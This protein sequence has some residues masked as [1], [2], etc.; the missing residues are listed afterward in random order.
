MR[1]LAA[2]AVVALALAAQAGAA[3]PPPAV[4]AQAQLLPAI[5]LF[6]DT[7]TAQVD[8]TLDRSRVDPDT[9][10]VEADFAPWEPVSEPERIRRDGAAT[11]HIRTRFVLRCLTGPCLPAQ[12][13]A[14]LEFG[15]AVVTYPGGE[16]V[17]AR[18][19]VLAVHSRIVSAEAPP[20]VGP[21]GGGRRRG[22]PEIPWRADV[23]A[24]PAPTYRVAPGIA[25]P[26]LLAGGSLLAACGLALGL[27]ALPRR[28]PA[29]APAPEPPPPPLPPLE[30]ALALLEDP[31]PADGAADRRRALELVADHVAARD[32]RLART[33]R[34]LAWREDLPPVEETSGLAARVR[35]A[36]AENGDA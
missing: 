13:V 17:Y 7:V 18:W 35:T 26:L 22:P 11:T 34:T 29:P 6:G 9:V 24:M 31:A 23:V 33:A 15:T 16:P 14:P 1:T 3:E 12:D 20:P 25:L 32:A 5:V 28:R 8:V 4:E 30:R 19:P 21:A 27:V 36:L 10:R 2:A